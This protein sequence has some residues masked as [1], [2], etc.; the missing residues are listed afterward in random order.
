MCTNED[1]VARVQYPLYFTLWQRLVLLFTGW[2]IIDS[3]I[4]VDEVIEVEGAYFE[5]EI[6]G[7][8]R[9]KAYTGEASVYGVEKETVN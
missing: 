8:R 3:R 1:I 5:V 2:V 6:V 7:R 9:G 4:M